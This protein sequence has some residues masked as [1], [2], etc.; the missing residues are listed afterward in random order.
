MFSRALGNSLC[1]VKYGNRMRR[2]WLPGNDA[3]GRSIT[4][5]DLELVAIHLD[6]FADGILA[7]E[8]RLLHVFA[9]HDDRQVVTALGVGEEAAE[10]HDRAAGGIGFLGASQIDAVDVIALVA[11]AVKR[12]PV[13]KQVGADVL[14]RRAALG[15]GARVLRR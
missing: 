2:S 6:P 12:V 7:G 15:D 10:F 13:G 11:R 14:H 4:P 9:D 8:E 3:A 1:M 5:I